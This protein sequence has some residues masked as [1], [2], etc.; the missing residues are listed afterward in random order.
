MAVK[1]L[2]SK[3]RSIDTLLFD[4]MNKLCTLSNNDTLIINIVGN[5]GGGVSSMIV[6]GYL[7]N[8]ESRISKVIF[9]DRIRSAGAMLWNIV[10]PDKR[11]ITKNTILKYHR[12]KSGIG[13]TIGV[14]AHDYILNVFREV[15]IDSFRTFASWMTD[16]LFDKLIDKYLTRKWMVVTPNDIDKVADVNLRCRD[17]AVTYNRV[18]LDPENKIDDI[19]DAIANITEDT[20]LVIMSDTWNVNGIL[21]NMEVVAYNIASNKNIKRILDCNG[22]DIHI[23]F[24]F[25]LN[26]ACKALGR[27]DLSYIVPAGLIYTTIISTI[28]L[29]DIQFP[30]PGANC[31]VVAESD[32]NEVHIGDKDDYGLKYIGELMQY[33][34]SI[35]GAIYKSEISLKEFAEIQYANAN[36]VSSYIYLPNNIDDSVYDKIDNISSNCK[37]SFINLESNITRDL[38]PYYNTIYEIPGGGEY[39]RKEG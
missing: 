34:H 20:E 6:L 33:M 11:I 32:L 27:T 19:Y 30:I 4:T 25:I 21:N 28:R 14:Y 26:E 24:I 15:S 37:I 36:G 9:G 12:E 23:A 29:S 22:T 38:T 17:S 10:K 5:M 39:I 13:T 7:I 18:Y 2:N 1:V 35:A 16:D 31:A 8:T 3:D